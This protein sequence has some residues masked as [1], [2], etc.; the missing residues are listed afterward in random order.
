MI[1]NHLLNCCIHSLMI[2]FIIKFNN[3]FIHSVIMFIN[4]L[5]KLIIHPPRNKVFYLMTYY[6]LLYKKKQNERWK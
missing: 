5:L 6:F 2:T 1:F 3:H 4:Y